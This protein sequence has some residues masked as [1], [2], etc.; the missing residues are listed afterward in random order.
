MAAGITELPA[1][2][3]GTAAFSTHEFGRKRNPTLTAELGV[4]AIIVAA[5]WTKHDGPLLG[6]QRKVGV[7]ESCANIAALSNAIG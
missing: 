4:V 7:K 1:R 3:A 2:R 6:F 5:R